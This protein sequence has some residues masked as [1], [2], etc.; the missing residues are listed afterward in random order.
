LKIGMSRR[1]F[2]LLLVVGST[3]S[4]LAERIAVPPAAHF[5]QPPAGGVVAPSVTL[6]RATVRARLAQIRA[7]N[8]A[9][10]RA[11]Q[12]AGVFPSNTYDESKLNVWRDRDGH[13][14]AAATIIDAS[15]EHELVAR[16]A[17]QSNF[18][19]LADVTSGPLMDWILV[20]GF[21]QD[22]IVA[23]QEPFARVRVE[24]PT[25]QVAIDARK[26]RAEDA[27]L[28]KR[29]A[30]VTRELVDNEQRSLDRATDRLMKNLPLASRL[31]SAS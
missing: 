5:A 3:S 31:I 11:Y 18:I 12:R 28:A 23:I 29:Y 15:G 24:P 27:R 17:E 19:R 30:D 10:F 16:V 21:T 14:C 13:L 4:A 22:E 2:A 20:S 25:P 1:L 6:D 7:A 26:R 9:R 8:L